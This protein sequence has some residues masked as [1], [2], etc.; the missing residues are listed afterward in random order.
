MNFMEQK[1]SFTFRLDENVIV[2]MLVISLL[3]FIILAFR[4]KSYQPCTPFTISSSAEYYYTGESIRFETD[5]RTFKKLHWNFGDNQEDETRITSAIHAYDQPGE[6]TVTLST[7]YLC[8]EDKTLIISPAPKVVNPSLPI[9]LF[10]C[11][12]T[13]EVGKPVLFKDTTAGATQWEWRFGVTPDVDATS[14]SFTYTYSTPGTKTVTLVINNNPE[15]G[16]S[17]KIVVKEATLVAQP[18]KPPKKTGPRI[19]DTPTYNGNNHGDP[20][21]E[22]EAPDIS[23][24]EL[25][26]ELRG[27]ANHD[28][29]YPIGY[30][31]KYTCNDPKIKINLNDKIIDFE[32][33]Y[34]RLHNLESA[35]EIR[36]KKFSVQIAR[37]E[38]TRCIWMLIVKCKIKSKV[39]NL[40]NSDL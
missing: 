20:P 29:K 13:A 4:Y 18:P 37:D 32:D 15:Q 5:A 30:F 34:N 39:L 31:Y 25:M 21:A 14:S 28:P 11:P 40:G 24:K 8:T 7:D 12:E 22:V 2:T 35:N 38:K 16:F 19:K 26:S 23:S 3:A 9:P 10:M 33:F 36:E 17:R 27:I 1:K 6:Y